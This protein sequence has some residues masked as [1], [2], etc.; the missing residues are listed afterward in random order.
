M[1][2]ILW[3]L[4]GFCGIAGGLSCFD[5]P[6]AAV[7]ALAVGVLFLRAAFGSKKQ[8]AAGSTAQPAVSGQAGQK[9]LPK[10]QVVYCRN[11]GQPLGSEAVFCGTCGTMRS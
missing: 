4:I 3:G 2:R 7:L 8:K 5:E 10:V 1:K 9:A 6:L 11:C